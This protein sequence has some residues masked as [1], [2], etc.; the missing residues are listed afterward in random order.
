MY[1]GIWD[2]IKSLTRADE[3]DIILSVLCLN[4]VHHNLFQLV[5]YIGLNKHR[6]THGRI[7]WPPHQWVATGKLQH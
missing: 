1:L 4:P 6:L 7:Y 2:G 3:H 5:R